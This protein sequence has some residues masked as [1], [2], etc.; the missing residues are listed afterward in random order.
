[1]DQSCVYNGLY[2]WGGCSLC[3][4]VTKG[5]S[6]Y[7]HRHSFS[8]AW[9]GSAHPPQGIHLQQGNGLYV[10]IS[11]LTLSISDLMKLNDNKYR[12]C[13]KIKALKV[14]KKYYIWFKPLKI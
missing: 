8:S 7:A 1:M 12:I 3:V 5:C 6:V 11:N 10:N 9:H 2:A 4:Y 14:I 13:A